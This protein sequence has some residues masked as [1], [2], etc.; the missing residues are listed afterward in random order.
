MFKMSGMR[1]ELLTDIDMHL[2]IEAGV[3]GGTEII[4]KRYADAN[5]PYVP[6]YNPEREK[7]YLLYL[8]CTNLYG[9]AMSQR[10]PYSGFRWLARD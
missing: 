8:D 5:K 10:L 4:S 1:L 6:D 9:T 7:N 3:R 2:F